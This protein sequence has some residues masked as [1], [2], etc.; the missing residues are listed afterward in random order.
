M[1]TIDGKAEDRDQW[2]CVRALSLSFSKLDCVD[3]D[4][5]DNEVLR[6]DLNY[7]LY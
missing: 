5:C 6:T 2:Q 1:F 3:D 4:D 7:Q